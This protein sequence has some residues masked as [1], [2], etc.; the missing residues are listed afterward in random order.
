MP[1]L[2]CVARGVKWLSLLPGGPSQ[3][4]REQR[5][6][7]RGTARR[8]MLDQFALLERY[9]VKGVTVYSDTYRSVCHCAVCA[10]RHPGRPRRAGDVRGSH[11]GTGRRRVG[12]LRTAA[13]YKPTGNKS[14]CFYDPKAACPSIERRSDLG[15]FADGD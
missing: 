9:L 14:A 5:W 15:D 8:V 13:F 6:A 10:A 3:G 7:G 2:A 11:D 1:A 12:G 4:G